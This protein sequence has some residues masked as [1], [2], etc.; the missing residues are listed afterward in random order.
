MEK[1]SDYNLLM[2]LYKEQSAELA[3]AR[4]KVT[5]TL[6]ELDEAKKELE[7]LKKKEE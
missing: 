1:L 5:Q 6:I 7:E 4:V 3:H 2:E